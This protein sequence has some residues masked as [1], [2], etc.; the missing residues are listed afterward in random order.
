MDAIPHDFSCYLLQVRL[1]KV[2]DVVE[3]LSEV[4]LE[5]GGL[6]V[7]LIVW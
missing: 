6:K 4:V 1:K 2:M 5:D 3:A 7:V